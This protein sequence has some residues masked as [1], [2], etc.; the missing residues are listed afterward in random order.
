MTPEE[1]DKKDAEDRA[2]VL[3]ELEALLA[4]HGWKFVTSRMKRVAAVTYELVRTD[5]HKLEVN[6]LLSDV[7][8]F[9][10]GN[11]LT[12]TLT[13]L[14]VRVCPLVAI[15][16]LMAVHAENKAHPMTPAE[17]ASG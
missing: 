3:A 4:P 12:E 2:K 10:L 1:R 11:L 8:R 16:L 13:D 6:L 15:R 9:D 17:A 14:G 5:G 7:L